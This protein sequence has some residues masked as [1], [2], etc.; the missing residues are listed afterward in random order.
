MFGGTADTRPFIPFHPDAYELTVNLALSPDDA[1]SGGRLIGLFNSR[2]QAV[3]RPEGDATVH[4]SQ[5]LHAVSKMTSG[6][7]YS[8]ILV[9]AHL[10][11]PHVLRSVEHRHTIAPHTPGA[12]VHPVPMLH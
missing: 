4:S 1:H 12:T 7:R 6:V 10:P 11:A 3:V 2:V 5:L 9:S 8:L